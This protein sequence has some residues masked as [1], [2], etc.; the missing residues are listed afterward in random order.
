[1]IIYCTAAQEPDA[2]VAAPVVIG[3]TVATVAKAG[4]VIQ[5][6]TIQKEVIKTEVAAPLEKPESITSSA[7]LPEGPEI[8]QGMLF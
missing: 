7:Q 2:V 8:P 4:E 6:Q 3:G 5:T 1:M